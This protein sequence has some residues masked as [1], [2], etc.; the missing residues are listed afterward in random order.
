[1]NLIN[2]SDGLVD[3]LR[4]VVRR[5]IQR[6]AAGDVKPGETVNYDHASHLL[7]IYDQLS[8]VA[9]KWNKN[10]PQFGS[11]AI[12]PNESYRSPDRHIAADIY[13]ARDGDLKPIPAPD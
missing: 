6:L 12:P 9:S 5:E 10:L 7:T 3:I 2:F 4:N 8:D 11:R 13:L 1:M